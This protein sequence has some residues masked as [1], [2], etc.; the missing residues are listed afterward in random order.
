VL[1]DAGLGSAQPLLETGR[2]P[3]HLANAPIMQV[4]KLH[5]EGFPNYFV[6]VH[7]QRLHR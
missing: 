1:G 5:W 3:K 6:H 4:N 7:C 2:W